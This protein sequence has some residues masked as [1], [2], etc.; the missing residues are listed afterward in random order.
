MKIILNDMR[1][2]VDIPTQLYCN[3]KSVMIV[4]HNPIHDRTK[5]IEIDRHFIIDYLDRALMV[6]NV[7]TRL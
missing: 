7:P 3:N 4:V 5:H 2:Q 1:I 6:T